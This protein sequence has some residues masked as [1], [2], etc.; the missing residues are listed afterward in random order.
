[1]RVLV[2]RPQPQA[3][4]WVERLRAA[5]FDAHALPLIAIEALS[6]AQP[7]REAWD[8]LAR[9]A[10]AVFVSPNAVA[11]F[12]AARLANEG[13]PAGVLAAGTGPGTAAA[14]HAHGVPD[15]LIVQPAAS[16]A[17]FDSE[18][19]WNAG[20]A[21][22][23]WAGRSVLIVR[24]DGGRDWLADTLA[25]RGANV[26]F[27]RSYARALPRLDAAGRRLLA[28]ALARPRE[29]LWLFS[30]S[31]AIAH[32]A[33]LAPPH[34]DWRA[35]RALATHPRIAASARAL[36]IADVHDAPPGEAQVIA[37]ISTMMG[38]S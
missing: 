18:A 12:F 31:Q 2:T 33:Q 20:L 9:D 7:L 4:Q 21:S 22:R 15:A 5:G 36:G 11:R 24:G 3:D 27:V 37:A 19:L 1:V 10:L 29:H 25:A 8:A 38:R 26:R 23:E 30:S 35:A 6:D 32:L 34:G 13:W 14:L 28:D 16:A 17:Q